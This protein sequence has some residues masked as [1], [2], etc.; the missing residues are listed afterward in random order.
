MAAAVHKSF[1]EETIHLATGPA[2][3]DGFFYDILIGDDAMK[4]KPVSTDAMAHIVSP[5]PLPQKG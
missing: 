3:D 5:P 1:P 2:T 4:S